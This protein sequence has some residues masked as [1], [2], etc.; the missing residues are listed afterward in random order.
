M[1]EYSI[2]SGVNTIDALQKLMDTNA[3]F[4]SKKFVKQWSKLI[5]ELDK[6]RGNLWLQSQSPSISYEKKLECQ[7]S[8]EE[9]QL[10]FAELK[11]MAEVVNEAYKKYPGSM[12]KPI[13]NAWAIFG[14]CLWGSLKIPFIFGFRLGNIFALKYGNTWKL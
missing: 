8:L 10:T 13:E 3:N 4:A 1:A 5:D 12:P 11:R 2:S 9:I 14:D 7:Q 6:K